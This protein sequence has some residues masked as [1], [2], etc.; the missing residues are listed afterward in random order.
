MAETKKLDAKY[1]KGLVF[2]FAEKKQVTEN[3]EHKTVYVPDERELTPDDV[4]AWR[5]AGS[6]II[7]VTADGRKHTVAK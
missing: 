1:L 2:Q 3:G 4:L 6:E 7:I 5:D